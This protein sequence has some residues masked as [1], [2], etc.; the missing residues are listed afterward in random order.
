[1]TT[2]HKSER[3]KQI[4]L[5]EGWKAEVKLNLARYEQTGEVSKVEWNVYARR[6]KETLHVLYQG[7]RFMASTYAYGSRRLYPARSGGVI[8]LLQGRPDP[9]KLEKQAPESLLESRSLP[10]RDDT[11]ALEILAAVIGKTITWVRKIDGEL[12]K[13]HVDKG[14][15]L[16]KPYFRL[17]ETK[18]GR[19][20]L[21]WQDREGFHSVALD[22]II[23][24]S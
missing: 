2:E 20:I 21:D 7:N 16:G 4:A 19:R 5:N 9:R 3:L 22:Q 8:K 17:Y 18:S 14:V 10:W 15:N 12:C 23:D 24:V 6:G 1:M 11:P 13:A